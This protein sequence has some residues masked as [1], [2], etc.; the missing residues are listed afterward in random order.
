MSASLE[1][2]LSDAFGSVDAF[3]EQFTQA[4]LSRFGS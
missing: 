3:K 4:A 1:K 2:A